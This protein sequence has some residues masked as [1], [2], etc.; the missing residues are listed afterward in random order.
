[1]KVDHGASATKLWNQFVKSGHLKDYEESNQAGGKESK[2]GS[3]IASAVCQQFATPLQVLKII[4]YMFTFFLYFNKNVQVLKSDNV[5]YFIS[6]III[7]VSRC[8]C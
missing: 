7:I 5:C 4:Y 1:V 3:T 6:L 8:V 2:L